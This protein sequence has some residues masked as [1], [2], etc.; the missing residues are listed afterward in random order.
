MAGMK[1][2]FENFMLMVC[3]RMLNGLHNFLGKATDVGTTIQFHDSKF[4]VHSLADRGA[5]V[6][7]EGGCQGTTNGCAGYK[8]LELPTAQPDADTT[9]SM[10]DKLIYNLHAYRR[11]RASGWNRAVVSMRR[12]ACDWCAR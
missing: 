10:T 6:K 12:G 11:Q 3:S 4:P 5:S 8:A 9:F 7:F 2:N 1:L